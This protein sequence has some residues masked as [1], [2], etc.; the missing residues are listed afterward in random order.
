MGGEKKKSVDNSQPYPISDTAILKGR[1]SCR[2]ALERLAHVWISTAADPDT[3]RL[4][5]HPAILL[6]SHHH[7]H[8]SK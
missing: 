2:M 5:T 1:M 4:L 3:I 8:P 7:F 6:D